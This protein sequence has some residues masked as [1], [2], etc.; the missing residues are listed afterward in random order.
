MAGPPSP[1][2]KVETE[3]A[4]VEERATAGAMG[5]G[6]AE[7]DGAERVLIVAPQPFYED[8]GTPIAVRQLIEALRQLGYGVDVLTFPVGAPLDLAGVR[9][10]RAANPLRIRRVPVGFSFRKLALDA[11][12]VVALRA[13]LRRERYVCVHAVEE[14]AFPALWLR[15]RHGVPVIYDMQSSLPEQ[16][17][18][19]PTLRH[20][21]RRARGALLR[22][23]RWL[24]RRADMVVSSSGLAERVRRLVPEARVREWRYA[25]AM[26]P[27]ADGSVAALR[28]SLRIPPG[29]PVVLYS[30]TF[31]PYQGLPTLL[32][33]ATAVLAAVPDAVFVL[34]GRTGVEI[35]AALP[36]LP[37]LEARGAVRVVERQPR[38]AMPHFLALADVLV[39]PRAYGGNLPL[40]VFDYLA[41]GRA[42]V[43]TDIPTHRAVLTDD[44]GVLVPPRAPALAQA[45][46]GLLRDAP[47]RARLG[48]AARAYAEAH[49]GWMSF[50]RSVGD[51]YGEVLARV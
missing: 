41:A 4:A 12:L 49:L 48:A 16:L 36:Q 5:R 9:L 7:D 24:L 26:P 37:A 38:E 25:S 35:G 28:A 15:G 11:T 29:A 6:E 32:D 22:A 8:R 50:V 47:R 40:K 17:L 39:S 51:L 34:V 13:Q 33:A 43:A 3:R 1:P 46:V 10:F 19:H 14:A 45:I 21:S 2:V 23:E 42:I 18:D 30:G 44:L 20:V 27:T 31:E